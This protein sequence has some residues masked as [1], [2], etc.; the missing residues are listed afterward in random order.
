[1]ISL[2]QLIRNEQMKIMD[3]TRTWIMLGLLIPIVSLLAIG[4]RLILVSGAPMDMWEFAEFCTHLLFIVQLITLVVA[5]DV[6]SGE[7]EWGTAK[8]LLIR[9]VSRT[10]IL[11][12]KFA[13]VLIFLLTGL[14][15][16]LISS[17]LFGAFL[18]RWEASAGHVPD[19]LIH[20]GVIYGLYGVQVT[21]TASLAFMLSAVSR[22][23]TLSVGLSIFLFF[24]G[25]ILSELFAMWGIDLGKYLLF[26][27][28][29]LSPYYLGISPSF[30]D[31][32]AVHSLTVLTIHFVLFHVI[33]WWS[34][35]KRDVLL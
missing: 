12:A 17:L 30:P 10:K 34:F 31:M 29:D 2:W 7:F 18:F 11:L 22:S 27:N 24:S 3:R 13:A 19:R 35:A 16:L 9:P 32:S 26:A 23:S 25:V 14:A 33:A 20:L 1:M 8:L 28:L 4:Q 6:I 15:V 5:G 21:V